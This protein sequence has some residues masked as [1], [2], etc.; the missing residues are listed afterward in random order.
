MSGVTC[1]A[2]GTGDS[3]RRGGKAHPLQCQCAPDLEVANDCPSIN[4][5]SDRLPATSAG[6]LR[7]AAAISAHFATRLIVL[8]VE[9]P[10]L[11]EALDL[12]TGVVWNLEDCERGMEQFAPQTFGAE[13]STLTA[14][15]YEVA[16]GKPAA[17]ILRV[18]RERSCDLIVI[19]T[20]GLTGIRP[21]CGSGGDGSAR[22]ASLGPA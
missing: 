2:S 16:V 1:S 3:A 7:S 15:E 21:L 12:G 14:L 18:A 4:L 20:H 5:V 19:R 6:A 11:A 10:L 9:D 17:E 13:S 8:S 22:F